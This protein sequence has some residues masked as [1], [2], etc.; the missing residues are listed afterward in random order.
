MPAPLYGGYL[1]WVGESGPILAELLRQGWCLPDDA[2]C[3]G[4]VC[5]GADAVGR[6]AVNPAPMCGEQPGAG[7]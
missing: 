2:L 3:S 6:G 4:V 7:G 5:C 1:G